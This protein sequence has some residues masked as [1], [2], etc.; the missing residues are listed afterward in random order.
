MRYDGQVAVITGAAGGIGGATAHLLA[1]RGA[2]VV[3]ADLNGDGARDQAA[4]IGPSAWAAGCDT[5]DPDQVDGLFDTV[6]D[7]YGR[8]D[9]VFANAG[10]G[11]VGSVLDTSFDD[12]RRAFDVNVHGTFLT[13]RA[14]AVRMVRHGTPGSIVVTSSTGAVVPTAMMA[15]YCSAKASLNMLVA[16]MA[17]ELGAHDIRV[18][19]VLPGVVST[20]MTQAILAAG[21]ED[22]VLS[23]VPL[24]RLGVPADVARTVCYLLSDEAAYVTGTALVVDGGGA[25]PGAG[26]YTNDF[27][28]RG[29]TTWRLQRSRGAR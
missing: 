26:W 3:L 7:R 29:A 6:V 9:L 10:W 2:T 18:N 23:N 15:A 24:G 21:A 22:H 17:Y 16:V 5:T 25:I 11:S 20:P 1:E 12:W 28:R 14:A 13:A 27:R 8:I 19:A 4:K